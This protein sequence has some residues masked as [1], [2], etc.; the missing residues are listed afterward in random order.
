MS[1]IRDD[2]KLRAFNVLMHEARHFWG[3]A[4]VVLTHHDEARAL[5]L[6]KPVE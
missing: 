4:M 3:R 5:D 6:V 1:R 2:D